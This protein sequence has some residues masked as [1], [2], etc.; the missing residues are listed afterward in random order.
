MAPQDAGGRV[1][2]RA[3]GYERKERDLYETPTWVTEAL[4][5]DCLCAD[6]KPMIW[7]PAAGS[8]AI[9]KP[10]R[11]AGFT[12]HASDLAGRDGD[13]PLMSDFLSTIAA[14]EGVRAVVTNPPYRL[15]QQ[16]IETAIEF[17]RPQKG[18]VA[19]L[20]R[21]DFDSASTRRHLFAD[22]EFWWRKVVLTKR[23]VWF[24]GGAS[25]SFNHAWYCWNFQC[26]TEP[27]IGY[28]P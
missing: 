25:P 20:L 13:T 6:A 26:P 5:A 23:I 10:L 7:E 14:P 16:F 2:Q 18:I 21:I 1:S 12:V 17:M 9:V 3:S 27:T 24:E 8:G 15:A 28:A 19:M 4:I 11:D 22:C